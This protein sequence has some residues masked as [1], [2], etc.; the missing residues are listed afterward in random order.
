MKSLTIPV[1]FIAAM[2]VIPISCK[3]KTPTDLT[4]ESIIPKPVSVTAAGESF[5]LKEKSAI[6]VEGGSE[7]ILKIGQYLADTLNPVTGLSTAVKTADAEPGSGNIYL[8]LSGAA[9]SLGEEGYELT[10]TKQLVK[11]TANKPAGLFR[12]IQTIRQIV[13]NDTISKKPGIFKISTGTIT[14][15][16]DYSVQ[17]NDA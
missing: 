12:G 9:E 13:T 1:L 15:Y 14:D 10:V 6:F 7:D 16:P 5:T 4:M 11:L 17:R 2:I 8:T 3:P